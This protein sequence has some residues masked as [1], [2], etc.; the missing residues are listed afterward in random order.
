[1]PKIWEVD[2]TSFSGATDVAYDNVGSQHLTVSSG[3]V[4]VA[5][6]TNYAFRPGVAFTNNTVK[7]AYAV[8]GS[9]A[10]NG[11]FRQTFNQRSFVTAVYFNGA[12]F[13]NTAFYDSSGDSTIWAEGASQASI[14]AGFVISQNVAPQSLVFKYSSASFLDTGLTSLSGWNILTATIDRIAIETRFYLN[15]TLVGMVAQVPDTVNTD[16]IVGDFGVNNEGTFQVGLVSTYDTILS[17][18]EINAIVDTGLKD[19][20]VGNTPFQ[21]FSGTLYGNTGNAVSGAKIYAIYDGLTTVASSGSTTSSG[22]YDLNL[23]YSG[24]YTVVF[25]SSP[26][27]GSRSVNVNAVASGVNVL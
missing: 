16:C 21:T 23:P 2:F 24:A 14:S 27:A 18:T 17:P 5:P 9:N 12:V 26:S 11:C 20:L 13:S 15:K 19:T 3:I 8:R 1:M 10:L 22:T 25:T 7:Q 4:K 6:L